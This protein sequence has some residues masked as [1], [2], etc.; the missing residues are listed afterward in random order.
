MISIPVCHYIA[1][2]KIPKFWKRAKE[3]DV[4][5]VHEGL[6]FVEKVQNKKDR[7]KELIR[8]PTIAH[9]SAYNKKTKG[10]GEHLNLEKQFLEKFKSIGHVYCL[11]SFIDK[12]LL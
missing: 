2:T 7:T 1:S 3:E 10:T 5:D 11:E 8:R 6:D 12:N 4:A 9:L